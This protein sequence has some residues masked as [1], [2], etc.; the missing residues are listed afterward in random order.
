V[1]TLH[2][3]P[4]KT[5]TIAAMNPTILAPIYRNTYRVSIADLP[6]A[7]KKLTNVMSFREQQSSNLHLFSMH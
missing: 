1:F 5:N 4:K 2:F 7:V 3:L 6:A